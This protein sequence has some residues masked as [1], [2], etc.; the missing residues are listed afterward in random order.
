MVSTKYKTIEKKV[1][2][3]RD[4]YPPIANK[5][6]KKSPTLRNSVDIRHT[7][8]DETRKK[9]RNGGG[10]FLLQ[11]EEE[12]F[13]GMLEQHGKAFAFTSKEIGCVDPK[14]VEASGADGD[15]QKLIMCRGT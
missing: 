2:R 6:R 15:L 3:S 9:L 1:N 8:T 7:F 13:C 10:G 5:R 14:I 11:E 12:R 4:R